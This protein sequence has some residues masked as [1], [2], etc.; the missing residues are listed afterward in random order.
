MQKALI[1]V[2]R[3]I[4]TITNLPEGSEKPETKVIVPYEQIGLVLLSGD[5]SRERTKSNCKGY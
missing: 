1:D 5:V 3:A 2:D 4:K